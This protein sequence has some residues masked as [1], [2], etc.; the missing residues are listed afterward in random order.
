MAQKAEIRS[1]FTDRVRKLLRDFWGMSLIFIVLILLIRGVEIFLVFR[2]H[3]LSFGPKE[4][5]VSSYFQDLGWALYF[6]GLLFIIHVSL[7]FISPRFSRILM[8]LILTLALIIQMGLVFYFIRTLL[9]LGKDLF[10][11][12]FND[13]YLTISSSGQLNAVNLIFGTLALGFIGGLLYLGIWIFNFGIRTYL[14]FTGVFF[15][16]LLGIT[17]FPNPLPEDAS[18]VRRNIELNKSRF[19]AEQTF[20]HF[21]F[22][23]EY[24]FDFYLRSN[25]QNYFVDK[26]YIDA[27][28][29]FLHQGE[30][31][32]VLGPFFDSLDQAPDIVFIL[33]ESF[34]KA[35]SGNGASLGSFTP[36]L[37]SLE[38]HS[39]VWTHALSSTGRTFGILPGILGGG[40]PFGEKGFLE[41]Y[42]EY[43]Y[44]K[45]LISVLRDNGYSAR[46]FIG[47]DRKFDHEGDF[48][49]YHQIDQLEDESTFLPQFE[50]TPTQSGFSWGYADKELFRNGLLKLPKQKTGPELRI[51]QTQTSHDP[52]IVP[53]RSIYEQKFNN[54]L[55][56]YLKINQTKI[57]EYNAYKDIYMTILYA[58]DAIKEFFREYQNRPEFANTIFIITGDHRLPEIP[59]S[60][61]LDRFH[62]PLIIYS[63]L[64]KQREIFKGVT[65]HFE[66]TPSILSFLKKNIGIQL[67][68]DL[69]WQGQVLDTARNFQSK[70]SM[71][72][73][74]N[75]N[76]LVDYLNG[77]FFLS[78]GQV[79]LISEGLNIDPIQDN[80]AL[81]RLNGEFE[82]FKNKN[83]YTVQTRKLQPYPV[84]GN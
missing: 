18:E 60:S 58:D 30:Y 53:E 25:N 54:H 64:L 9:P 16:L 78:D 20:E 77:E 68:Q 55:R 67:P 38:Q 36:F 56:D 75:K 17:I 71:P 43:P 70:I 19:L 80:E 42:P 73:M 3:V 26:N 52:Y 57:Q 41:L 35:Y 48:L 62:V 50:R 5:L 15:I 59:M 27:E 61:R 6:L 2:S 4:I 45:S 49:E 46:F 10:A 40:L 51:F 74:R 76:Q 37:D 12:N 79:F 81:T 66:I 14:T 7:S 65:S 39:L 69:I 21:I 33:A 29:P 22:G 63:P 8:Q 31:P 13:L 47:A 24:Y 44:H 72:L 28:Y 32:D 23:G 83:S 1:T 34:G 82:E 84:I 11:Y